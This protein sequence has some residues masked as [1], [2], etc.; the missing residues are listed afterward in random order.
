MAA[1][2]SG[3]EVSTIAPDRPAGDG[4]P[5][6]DR[7]LALLRVPLLVKILV[8]NLVLVGAAVV[9]GVCL[10]QRARTD[11]VFDPLVLLVGGAAL[12][13]T[14]VLNGVIVWLALRPLAALEDTAAR[15][16]SGDAGARVPVSPL[17]DR[18]FAR[19]VQTFN[20]VLDAAESN[21]RRLREVAARSM[22][23]AEE[24][25]IRIARELHDGVAQT[26]AAM[27]LRLRLART[28][29]TPEDQDKA[30]EALSA[31]LADAIEELRGIALGLRPPALDLLGLKPAVESLV[32]SLAGAG[33]LETEVAADVED[34]RRLAPEIELALYR[35]LQEALSNV[36]RHADAR[37]VA[38]QLRDRNGTV[39]LVVE[40]DGRGFVAEDRIAGP[41]GLG[42]LGMQER[43]AYVGGDVEIVSVP[44]VGTR[45]TAA[46][47]RAEA[48]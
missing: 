4:H 24:E 6:S 33:Q 15:V 30:L 32:R 38:V 8:A 42:L 44:G 13:M 39:R 48:T 10:A 40:D 36:V 41:G 11:G 27:R 35:I 20:G 31:D 14:V 22:N 9:A 21:R 2:S 28:A 7:L 34:G 3:P 47:P 17:A 1:G 12:V 18:S 26:L 16:A 45:V 19:V 25:R 37:R 23:V 43:A 29:R 5:P 46:I